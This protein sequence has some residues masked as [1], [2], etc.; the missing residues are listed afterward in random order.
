MPRREYAAIPVRPRH[1]AKRTPKPPN[2]GPD[3][4]GVHSPAQAPG[5]RPVLSVEAR[6]LRVAELYLERY[7]QDEIAERVGVS[8]PTISRD[9]DAIR[10]AWR[11]KCA[12]LFTEQVNR[13]LA[14]LEALEVAYMDGWRRSCGESTTRTLDET[15]T[16]VTGDGDGGKNADDRYVVTER[17][18]KVTNRQL[19][20]NP[21]FLAGV[22]RCVAM[23][24]RIVTLTEPTGEGGDVP[25]AVRTLV[26][27][28]ADL[29][30]VAAPVY[31]PVA[32]EAAS[33]AAANRR[34]V[35]RGLPPVSDAVVV[36]P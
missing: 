8:Q 17:K 4:A 26:A 11:V 36:G 1:V 14:Q 24:L 23:R 12:S 28:L 33:T 21:A 30:A 19:V 15:S 7:R 27:S 34:A 22:E 9:L 32:V 10:Q 35:E 16:R 31:D 6:R 18:R 2:D 3:R 20:G 29:R 25:D 13:A 5:A